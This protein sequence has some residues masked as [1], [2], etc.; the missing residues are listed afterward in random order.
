MH[1]MKQTSITMNKSELLFK[2]NMIRERSLHLLLFILTA[3]LV[4]F[5]G[6]GDFV[7]SVALSSHSLR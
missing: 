3:V 7:V 5:I 1:G 6:G 2:M 4:I